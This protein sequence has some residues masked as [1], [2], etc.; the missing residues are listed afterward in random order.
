M[1]GP[2]SQTTDQR[3]LLF[4]GNRWV[5]TIYNN[6]GRTKQK[7][8]LQILEELQPD[9]ERS[10]R[11]SRP[12][13]PH[14]PEICINLDMSKIIHYNNYYQVRKAVKEM[15]E[16]P[17]NI[18]NDISFKKQ[19]YVE[20]PLLCGFEA[21]SNNK[22]ITL[23]FKRSTIELLTHVDFNRTK[24]KAFQYTKFDPFTIRQSSTKYMHPLYQLICSYSE[25]G[26]F[27]MGIDELR[28]QLQ[29][30]E[31]YKGFDNF[32][33][34]VLKHVQKEL[35]IFGAYGYN[36]SLVKEGKVVKKVVFKIF[37][38][39]KYDPN[40]VWVRLQRALTE[41]LPY[42]VR[43]NEEQ[44]EQFNY[45]LTGK[46]DLDQVLTKFQHI[47]KALVKR[48][49]SGDKVNNPFSYTIKAIREQFP[50]G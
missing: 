27:T 36:F 25:K 29:V 20:R 1:A 41:D 17:I 49:D 19:I 24:N 8:L 30:E 11:G 50:P 46:H 23:R 31:K 22:I 35:Q 14:V 2:G 4:I 44:L 7:I 47:H 21:T 9:I 6:Y 28:T 16:Q 12:V 39:K 13:I 37:S 32:H 42:F 38:N 34:F 40:H 15:S 18:Y 33:R 5:N 10:R 26:G 43:F 3:P 48:K 45:L